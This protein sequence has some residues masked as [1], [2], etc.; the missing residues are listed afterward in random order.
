MMPYLI[1][2]FNDLIVAL[3]KSHEKYNNSKLWLQLFWET[4][5]LLILHLIFLNIII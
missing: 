3:A 5:N 1:L 2:T 4:Y